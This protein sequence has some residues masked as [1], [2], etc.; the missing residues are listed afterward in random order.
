VTFHGAFYYYVVCTRIFYQ[1]TKLGPFSFAI[2]VE[3]IFWTA[4]C[5]VNGL[6]ESEF[7]EDLHDDLF[8]NF[9][10]VPISKKNEEL[11]KLL[12]KVAYMVLLLL[13]LLLLLYIIIIY[14]YNFKE[15]QRDRTLIRSSFFR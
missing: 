1:Q 5:Y 2:S 9:N 4:F 14:Y 11:K 6:C 8:T 15:K 13:L 7:M 3:E 12:E 10:E